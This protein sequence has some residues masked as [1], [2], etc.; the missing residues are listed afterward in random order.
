MFW[1]WVYG[2]VRTLYFGNRLKSWF[3][4]RLRSSWWKRLEHLWSRLSSRQSR[5]QFDSIRYYKTKSSKRQTDRSFCIHQF[6]RQRV[7]YQ[8][9]QLKK[10][11]WTVG[12]AC[13][14][15]CCCRKDISWR[16]YWLV[17][18]WWLWSERGSR[19][20]KGL[21]IGERVWWESLLC[22]NYK[23]HYH[24]LIIKRFTSKIK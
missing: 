2:K 5:N 15:L 14:W 16:R 22:L 12:L 13:L 9:R 4:V 17:F 24:I 20:V 19:G 8:W 21:N 18:I 10:W 3:A 11:Y 7:E 1:P 6:H 23:K